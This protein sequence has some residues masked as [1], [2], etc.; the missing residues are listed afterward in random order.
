V[1][2]PHFSEIYDY[3]KKAHEISR[4]S[5]SF[6]IVAAGLHPS[7]SELF[8]DLIDGGVNLSLIFD[9]P[10]IDKIMKDNYNELQELLSNRQ[11]ALY[12]YPQKM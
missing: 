10:L 7:F 2:H 1:V 3:N 4:C 6:S 8:S 12:R 11:V 5:K 9:V